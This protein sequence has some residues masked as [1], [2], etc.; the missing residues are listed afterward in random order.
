MPRFV[1]VLTEGDISSDMT[2]AIENQGYKLKRHTDYKGY[3]TNEFE[4]KEV[5]HVVA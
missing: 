5:V 1:T 2:E 3:V 4:R